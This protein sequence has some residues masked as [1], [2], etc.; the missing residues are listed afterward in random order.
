M[1]ELC[2]EET[3]KQGQGKLTSLAYDLNEL[4]DNLKSLAY[5]D[6]KPHTNDMKIVDIKARNAIK[7]L[8]EEFL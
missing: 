4:A 8:V 2:D 6:I 1:C 5:G 3:R 7:L